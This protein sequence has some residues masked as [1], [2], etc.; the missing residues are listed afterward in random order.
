MTD[1]TGWTPQ[2]WGGLVALG[3][4]LGHWNRRRQMGNALESLGPD[5]TLEDMA[6]ALLDS[7]P[8]AALKTM[9]EARQ[10]Q[11]LEAHRGRQEAPMGYRWGDDGNLSFIPGGPQDPSV[12][13]TMGDRPNAPQGYVW[14]DPEN[15]MAGLD[16][17]PGGPAE[18]VPAEVAA[19]S[20]MSKSFIDQAPSIRS[21]LAAG[22]L[23]GPANAAKGLAGIGRQGELRRQID[24]GSEALLRNLTGAGM[25]ESEARNYVRRYQFSATDGPQQQVSKLDQLL[26]ELQ[27]VETEI[28]RGRGGMPGAEPEGV[29]QTNNYNDEGSSWEV[30]PAG[31]QVVPQN[32]AG[33]AT[34]P[35][36][37]RDPA[38]QPKQEWV[39]KLMA[40]LAQYPD[41]A[42]Q[43]EIMEEW[44]RHYGLGAGAADR[45][46]GRDVQA[47]R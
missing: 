41:P 24:S 45:F 44:E 11:A 1:L 47:G 14:R 5:A 35:N 9:I 15:P 31:A 6:R 29:P 10:A 27:Y 26:R 30:D 20:G 16:P 18:R 43:K 17:V 37:M 46:L 8:E 33:M 13:R 3:G 4:G 23:S 39:Q 12:K 19:R 7:N 2:N 28:R 40:K 36:G 22:E 42:D 25:N 32:E 38:P 34:L 21:A